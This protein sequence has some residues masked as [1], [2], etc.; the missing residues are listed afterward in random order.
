MKYIVAYNG[1]VLAV[2]RFKPKVGV[3]ETRIFFLITSYYFITIF[4][5]FIWFYFA[6]IYT[7]M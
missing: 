6:K 1:I 5:M 7:S 4:V 3:A 2:F